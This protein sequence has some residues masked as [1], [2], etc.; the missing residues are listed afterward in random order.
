MD[1]VRRR[2]RGRH[3][4]LFVES[5]RR[6]HRVSSRDVFHAARVSRASMPHLLRSCVQL[7][8]G[9][10]R[11][12]LHVHLGR[13]AVS[14]PPCAGLRRVPLHVQPARRGALPFGALRTVQLR[15][16]RRGRKAACARF[17]SKVTSLAARAG[18]RLGAHHAFAQLVRDSTWR[19]HPRAPVT[20]KR[21]PHVRCSARV[22]DAS[23][24]HPKRAR[25]DAQ[26]CPC[27]SSRLVFCGGSSPRMCLTRSTRAWKLLGSFTAN[28]A[29]I[30]RF[31]STLS[32]LSPCM[33]WPYLIPCSRAPA[34]IRWIHKLR[35]SRF[36]CLRSR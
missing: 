20:C 4:R 12:R 10:R 26:A 2:R 3:L 5:T 24:R 17:G 29:S 23:S 9:G 33:S 1:R 14:H 28:S 22:I 6:L 15:A 25:G 31:T 16:G 21:R 8:P 35:M 7:H 30:I 32:C 19:T 27:A 13:T 11:R 36:F 18:F 34:L